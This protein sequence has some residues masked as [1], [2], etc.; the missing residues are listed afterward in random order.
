MGLS[1]ARRGRE[2]DAIPRN[3]TWEYRFRQEIQFCG[4]LHSH[5]V[6]DHLP[7]PLLFPRLDDNGAR[8]PGTGCV[9]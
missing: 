2:Y 3:G 8:S 6:L 4:L 5:F 7:F 1:A 9:N